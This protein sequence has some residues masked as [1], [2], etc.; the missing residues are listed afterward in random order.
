MPTSF[1]CFFIQCPKLLPPLPLS[2][3][4]FTFKF[5][6]MLVFFLIFFNYSFV[7]SFNSFHS[8]RFLFPIFSRPFFKC[9][10]YL[11]L[12]P[13]QNRPIFVILLNATFKACQSP[14]AKGPDSSWN[15]F[16]L[17]FAVECHANKKASNLFV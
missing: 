14:V 15:F 10:P 2:F 12:I 4:F 16:F 7:I 8:F 11:H 6:F 9:L 1:N 5:F 3:S 13:A 17:F